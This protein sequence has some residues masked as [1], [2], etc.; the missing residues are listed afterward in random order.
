MHTA[1]KVSSVFILH[2]S[3]L[4]IS[5]CNSAYSEIKRDKETAVTTTESLRA[6]SEALKPLY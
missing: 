5:F 2:A 6:E 3:A 1:N 4:S